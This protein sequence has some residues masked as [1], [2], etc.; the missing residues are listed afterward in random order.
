MSDVQTYYRFKTT[1]KR[2]SMKICN[3][4]NNTL[5]DDNKFCN[6]C[7]TPYVEDASPET[8]A[9][10]E[11][12]SEDSS[13]FDLTKS[14]RYAKNLNA[15]PQQLDKNKNHLPSVLLI[16]A[17]FIF[18][19]EDEVYYF[20]LILTFT[21]MFVWN[22]QINYAKNPNSI[23][24]P[25]TIVDTKNR[26]LEK[27]HR[28]E[29]PSIVR[30]RSN[31]ILV[32]LIL[33]IILM[34]FE[35]VIVFGIALIVITVIAFLRDK[36][37]L[38][39]T[40]FNSIDFT[41][42]SNFPFFISYLGLVNLINF[43]FFQSYFHF[44]FELTMIIN[45]FALILLGL[46]IYIIQP[47]DQ[48][49]KE[50]NI[51][52]QF[53][54]IIFLILAYSLALW[55][56]ISGSWFWIFSWSFVAV[57]SAQLIMKYPKIDESLF[58]SDKTKSPT[59]AKGYAQID[60][61]RDQVP[62]NA[63]ST[64]QSIQQQYQYDQAKNLVE[65]EKI[66]AS[67]RGDLSNLS[68]LLYRFEYRHNNLIKKY[69]EFESQIYNLIPEKLNKISI[70]ISKGDEKVYVTRR[71]L[72]ST[73]VDTVRAKNEI[74]SIDR[75]FDEI[76]H[77]FST[78]KI[79][80]QLETFEMKLYEMRER[81]QVIDKNINDK[82]LI[83]I[84][85][86]EVLLDTLNTLE[87]KINKLEQ[88]IPRVEP[89]P[90]KKQKS[91][92]KT[93][94]AITTTKV[95]SKSQIEY[96][97]ATFKLKSLISEKIISNLFAY[98]GALFITL[99][100]FFLLNFTYNNFI[101][102]SF[103]ADVERGQ[104]IFGTSMTYVLGLIFALSS[105]FLPRMKSKLIGISRLITSLGLVVIQFAFFVQTTYFV[106]LHLDANYLIF[107][108]IILVI[109]GLVIGYLL[110]SQ[111]VSLV[112]IGIGMY[113]GLI[114]GSGQ[115]DSSLSVLKDT[116][117]GGAGGPF[118]IFIF[119]TL[120]LVI[121]VVLVSRR[122]IWLPLVVFSLLSPVIWQ[123]LNVQSAI[124]TPSYLVLFVAIAIIFVVITKKMPTPK[125]FTHFIGLLFLIYPNIMGI[126]YTLEESTSVNQS[127]MTSL[128]IINIIV[129]FSSFY[130]LYWVFVF[131]EKNI[132]LSFQF[133]VSFNFSTEKL[134]L[135]PIQ[136]RLNWLLLTSLI[137]LYSIVSVLRSTGNYDPI[138][139]FG[140][141]LAIMAGIGIKLN[142]NEY[143]KNSIILMLIEAEVVF[144]L[145][146][147]NPNASSIGVSIV[148]AIFLVSFLS[149]YQI[150][151]RYRRSI[152]FYKLKIS[153]YQLAVFISAISIVNFLLAAESEEFGT[154]VLL[155][156]S[157]TWI[158]LTAYSI[159]TRR[160][161]VMNAKIAHTGIISG[162]AFLFVYGLLRQNKRFPIDPLTKSMS[163]LTHTSV[164]LSLGLYLIFALIMIIFG[165][166][167]KY[168][169][170]VRTAF[171]TTKSFFTNAKQL[172]V[173]DQLYTSHIII[174]ALP[175]ILIAFGF[176]YFYYPTINQAVLMLYFVVYF[177]LLPLLVIISRIKRNHVFGTLAA[178]TGYF[179]FLGGFVL[180]GG[181][182]KL[183]D[184]IVQPPV[185]SAR[186]VY[187][188]DPE[189]AIF[190]IVI[191]FIATVAWVIAL[192][193]KPLKRDLSPKLRSEKDEDKSK[194]S[195]NSGET[196]KEETK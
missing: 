66:G 161:D 56:D 72:D 102:V 73:K 34:N 128:Q 68:N 96:G 113:N 69:E 148:T 94:R 138:I 64:I 12:I 81:V 89:V 22:R 33:G 63:Q 169:K 91:L 1:Q 193:N 85:S 59:N 127:T 30:T 35:D 84:K 171:S 179:T 143:V 7:G 17:I 182:K 78:T 9:V 114:M 108:G 52:N 47:P 158:G 187:F 53:W 45:S 124:M 141:L 146:L 164:N 110:R 104:A 49:R 130:I 8:N 88:S 134:K 167:L 21:A 76:K 149:N 57:I 174:F 173:P 43:V 54:S 123:T 192:S 115:G 103:P 101:L 90:I 157:I 151:N 29:E 177:L 20:S 162:L 24:L 165:N 75:T 32:L 119:N 137:L 25:I 50:N 132:E 155:L 195:D 125:P 18:I 10:G 168:N 62:V 51:T 2:N 150:V 86:P 191:I 14:V 39:Q 11:D 126:I 120:L 156:S 106:N 183:Y 133:P 105:V 178:F 38:Q 181:A 136:Q 109:S 172:M 140:L 31:D 95:E 159:I 92:L 163:A 188:I 37:E 160:K 60:P 129:I 97:T 15:E 4:C 131:F 87:E 70:G 40:R 175:S 176:P 46:I 170:T 41:K 77:E 5:K 100:F 194:V 67:G 144:F 71:L 184:I 28:T 19:I 3:N 58:L 23:K 145:S 121:C 185:S 36:G 42:R 142:F 196:E 122:Q 117:F 27:I 186:G 107:P 116:L 26:W 118:A 98:V 13:S 190:L 154:L 93:Q 99:G 112:A 189:W 135:R 48:I 139:F 80:D 180:L 61:N 153:P 111:L 55:S 79:L 82:E 16:L 74:K 166:N 83:Y 44:R 65:S 6:Q 147:E 152:N